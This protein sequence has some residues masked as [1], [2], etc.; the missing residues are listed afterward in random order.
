MSYVSPVYC[1]DE[2]LAVRATGDFANLCPPW[3][4]LAAGSDGVFDEDDLWTISS[5]STDFAEAGLAV[6]H[7][8]HLTLPKSR[9][10]PSGHLYAVS[11]A[12]LDGTLTL[13]NVGMAA[14]LGVPPGPVGGLNG[15]TFEVPTFTPQI[16]EVSYRIN[17]DYRIDALDPDREPAD[18]YDR[19]ELRDL[20]VLMVLRQQYVMEN[21]S[22]TGDYKMKIDRLDTELGILGPRISIRWGPTGEDSPPSNTY[23]KS[24]FR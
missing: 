23:N 24:L 9:Y 6:G 15:L 10:G 1:T 2:D 22:E 7:V 3:Q 12:N 18:L 21:R 20:A 11:T 16:E 4:R 5:A 19:R 8:V 13:R 17:R 14:G